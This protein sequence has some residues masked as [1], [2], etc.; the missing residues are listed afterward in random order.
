MSCI[1]DKCDFKSKQQIGVGNGTLNVNTGFYLQ[2]RIRWPYSC[3][4]GIFN[5]VVLK[6]YLSTN[7]AEPICYCWPFAE[8]CWVCLRLLTFLFDRTSDY[9]Y[10]EWVKINKLGE[11]HIWIFHTIFILKSTLIWQGQ[12]NIIWYSQCIQIMRWFPVHNA[13]LAKQVYLRAFCYQKVSTHRKH[14]NLWFVCTGNIAL[15]SQIIGTL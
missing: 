5:K 14:R 12:G 13:L 4:H 1:K 11:Q 3:L 6:K 10:T 8:V 2:G 7:D 9:R 15:I